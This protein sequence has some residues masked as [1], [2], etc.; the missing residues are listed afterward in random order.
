MD[1]AFALARP[2]VGRLDLE[3]LAHLEE[4]RAWDAHPQRCAAHHAARETNQLRFWGIAPSFAFVQEPE[5]NGVAERFNRTLTEQVI[6]G[7]IFR[8]LEELRGAVGEF[9][10]RYNDQWLV[11]KM[12]FMAPNQAR[13]QFE[14]RLA[15]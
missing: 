5:T 4:R 12:G 8:N 6:H 7:R 10:R 2:E 9:V 1:G 15:A 13:E 14:L 3:R 11:E